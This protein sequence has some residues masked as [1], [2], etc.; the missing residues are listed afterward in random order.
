[1]EFDIE[2]ASNEWMDEGDYDKIRIPPQL[3]AKLGILVGQ[4]L[5]VRGRETVILQ[6]AGCSPAFE[7]A[8]VNV[9]NFAKIHGPDVQFEILDVTLGCDPEFFIIHGNGPHNDQ[10]MSAATYLPYRGRI[11]CDGCL[12]ELRPHYGRHEDDVVRELQTLVPRIPGSMERSTWARTLPTDGNAFRYEA[13]SYYFARAAGFH[14]HLGIPPEILNTRQDFNRVAIDHLIQCLD[15]YVS[16]PLVPLEDSPLRRMGKTQYGL[17]GDY[18]PHNLT[19]EYR[20]PGAFYLR[21]PTLTRGLLG[22]C[23]MITELVVSRLKI[24]SKNFIDLRR[25]NKSDLQEVMQIPDSG[26]IK[27]TLLAESV[28][29]AQ[30]ELEHIHKQL[31]ELPN[32]GKHEQTV[33]GFFREVGEGNR[34]GPNLL[35]NWAQKE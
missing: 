2:Q 35:R 31:T 11:G 3:R 10:I 15:W 13:H 23:L 24:A 17:P 21:T 20:T 7:T 34:P 5:Q 12:G 19:L 6:V 28:G 14:V 9:E 27:S 25:L 26:T 33:E 16:V 22:L 32:Y 1:L 18:R 30:R 29:P 8:L 4:F